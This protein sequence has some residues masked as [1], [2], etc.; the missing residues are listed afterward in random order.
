LSRSRPY[1]Y[2]AGIILGAW[3]ELYSTAYAQMGGAGQLGGF[4]GGVGAIPSIPGTPYGGATDP[5][6]V[7]VTEGFRII[8]S[9][10][11]GQ[12][13][14]S[15]VFFVPPSSRP[16]LKPE[17]F[18]TTAVPQI[19]GLHKGSLISV[20]ATASAI[21][22][23]YDR[24]PDLNY[25]GAN[26][27]LLVDASKLLDQWR[28][29][30]T[31]TVTERYTYTPQAPAFLSGNVDG[32]GGNPL[33]TGYQVG[34][35]NTRINYVSVNGETP[36]NETVSLIG[37]YDNSSRNYSASDVQQ[38]SP[39]FSLHAQIY[40]AG[41][42]AKL[43]PL[44]KLSLQYSGSEF[45]YKPGSIG[46]FSTNGGTLGWFRVFSPTVSMN[47]NVGAQVVQSHF[48]GAQ[49]AAILAPVGA[50][51]VRWE[52]HVTTIAL[53]YTLR[54]EP[55]LQFQSQVLLTQTASFTVTQVTAI[56]ELLVIFNLNHS[57]GNHYGPISGSGSPISYISYGATGG[58][59]YKVT[60]QTF[61]GLNY[62]YSTFDNKFGGQSFSFDRNV[63]Q[64]TVSHAFY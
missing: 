1:A 30:T 32:A 48:R 28:K 2:L 5:S 43:T 50:F 61:L 60:S 9:I 14:D 62:S 23:Y 45:Q 33:V 63:V 13:Y 54:P 57:R 35:V 42:A 44:D 25:V 53:A 27:G 56:P 18:V 34:R 10:L 36:L 22:E 19:R 38:V 64:V 52:D 59:V 11:I 3:L 21:G 55:S 40:S 29:G 47:S 12:R 46:S 39:L 16:G 51:G 24:N 49:G 8:P 58:L 17:D 37:S 4:T 26:A 6:M 7:Q 41:I 31:F 15:N 20:N